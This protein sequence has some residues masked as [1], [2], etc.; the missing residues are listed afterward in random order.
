MTRESLANWIWL[1]LV[2]NVLYFVNWQINPPLARF[3]LT[4][5][6]LFLILSIF[7]VVFLVSSV[8]YQFRPDDSLRLRRSQWFVIAASVLI[9]A[10]NAYQTERVIRLFF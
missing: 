7:T 6:K 4:A 3:D 5:G 2:V 8:Y 9:F 1:L 10:L